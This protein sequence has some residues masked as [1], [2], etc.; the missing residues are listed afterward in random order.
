MPYRVEDLIKMR[1]EIPGEEQ[2][3]VTERLWD[4][5]LFNLRMSLGA[6]NN[7]EIGCRYANT[8]V[9][10]ITAMANVDPGATHFSIDPFIDRAY[11]GT[12]I[13]NYAI[14]DP[15]C[16]LVKYK[17]VIFDYSPELLN[18]LVAIP[19]YSQDVIKHSPYVTDFERAP[20][21]LLFIDGDHS[22]AGVEADVVN[23]HR[24]VKVGGAMAF[25]DWGGFGVTE[26]YEAARSKMVG[27]WSEPINFVHSRVYMTRLA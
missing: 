1:R 18:Q 3:L 17:E 14:S 20:V 11:I 23:Y 12:Y 6:G 22:A 2:A 8:T 7:I 4:S 9:P 19:G 24:F 13:E 21:A 10:M 27:R 16:Y 5:T 26:G 15:D 25:D